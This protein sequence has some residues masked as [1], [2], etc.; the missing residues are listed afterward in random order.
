MPKG[1]KG[2]GY[3]NRKDGGAGPEFL[4]QNKKV[5]AVIIREQDR[6]LL[7]DHSF[8]FSPGLLEFL[9]VLQDDVIQHSLK[10]QGEQG[11]AIGHQ[12]Y[13]PMEVWGKVLLPCP[14]T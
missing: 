10:S 7:V 12:H 14:L 11:S 6:R 13:M 1:A 4:A 5:S 3:L 9:K 2:R 8:S